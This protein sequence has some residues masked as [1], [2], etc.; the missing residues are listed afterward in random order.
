MP[1]SIALAQ[2]YVPVLDG[3]YKR[4]SLTARLLGANALIRFD[5]AN[6]VRV[7]KTDVDG[8]ADYSRANGFVK[9]SV[10]ASWETY[11][12]T[13]DRGVELNVDRMDRV[14]A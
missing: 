10:T 1:N 7:F 12:L 2:K 4:E 9:G 14:A 13:K 5:G 11:T 3:I 6:T 8:Y